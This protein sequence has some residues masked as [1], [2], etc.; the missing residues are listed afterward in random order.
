MKNL[1]ILFLLPPNR[2]YLLLFVFGVTLIITIAMQLKS[3][4]I[5]Y[6]AGSMGI[7]CGVRDQELTS[8]VCPLHDYSFLC[9]IG[10]CSHQDLSITHTIS[11]NNFTFL[12]NPL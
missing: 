4:V 8:L 10:L 11:C 3:H 9:W 7:L 6:L 2:I 5:N 1:K 12:S